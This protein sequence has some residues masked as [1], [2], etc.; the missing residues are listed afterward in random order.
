MIVEL[1]AVTDTPW[2]YDKIE[3][4]T[5]KLLR[6]LV[7]L[8]LIQRIY[9]KERDLS[10]TTMDLSEALKIGRI[11]YKNGIFKGQFNARITKELKNY[12][13]T[14]DR[15]EG[16]FRLSVLSVGLRLK[17]KKAED[18]FERKISFVNDYLN[19]VEFDQ[20]SNKLKLITIFILYLTKIEKE[21]SIN[22]KGVVKPRLLSTEDKNLIAA[23]WQEE[24]QEKLKKTI[25]KEVQN[26]KL[27]LL[28]VTSL[29]IPYKSMIKEIEK[30]FEKASNKAKVLAQDEVRFL[31]SKFIEAQY[32]SLGLMEYKWNCVDMPHDKPPPAP[33]I[34]GN[35]RWSHSILNKTIQRWDNPPITT[36]PGEPVRRCSVGQDYGCRCFPTPVYK[37]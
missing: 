21:L 12:G 34:L 9:V 24:I 35:V 3:Q 8:P 16:G 17:I 15:N 27:T 33:H 14:W 26:I 13:S 32:V 1:D 23:K 20:P 31:V 37:I 29:E 6:N 28:N 22:L 30:S 10:A 2:F 18:F 7:Y 19:S 11:S 4:D 5:K 36:N 25:D